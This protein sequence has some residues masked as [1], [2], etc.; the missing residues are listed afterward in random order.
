MEHGPVYV[1]CGRGPCLWGHARLS[2]SGPQQKSVFRPSYSIFPSLIQSF[3]CVRKGHK[4]PVT[5][6][7]TDHFRGPCRCQ[8]GGFQDVP[9]S[10]LS[11]RCPNAIS[12]RTNLGSVDQDTRIPH[13]GEGLF[14]K[15]RLFYPAQW[16]MSAYQCSEAHKPVRISGSM[17]LADPSQNHHPPHKNLRK[18]IRLTSCQHELIK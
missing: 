18:C 15:F 17:G 4:Q 2:R 8:T 12:R 13:H 16:F 9:N 1:C 7:A 11:G 5:P 14:A 10:M 3:G 6:E